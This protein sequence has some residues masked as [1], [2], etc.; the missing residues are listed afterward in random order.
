MYI[1]QSTIYDCNTE[2]KQYIHAM[3]NM[4]QNALHIRSKSEIF[5]V[6]KGLISGKLHQKSQT[7]HD[8]QS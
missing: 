5:V 8:K 2:I 1:V 6:N 4:K 3:S 7:K